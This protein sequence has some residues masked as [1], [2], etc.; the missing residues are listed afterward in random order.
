MNSVPPSRNT[1]PEAPRAG[2]YLLP[3]G[4][5]GIWPAVPPGRV[6]VRPAE[7]AGRERAVEN[8]S[9]VG[10]VGPVAGRVL[11]RSPAPRPFTGTATC[12][13]YAGHG[14]VGGLAGPADCPPAARG[15]AG[16]LRS[17]RSAPELWRTSW[18][19]P[20]TILI[21]GCAGR[22]TLWRRAGIPELAVA[23]PGR[24]ETG[25]AGATSDRTASSGQCAVKHE[26]SRSV[27]L[28]RP[29]PTLC[30]R[31]VRAF[32]EGPSTSGCSPGWSPGPAARSSR[33]VITDGR[34][35]RGARS[36][37]IRTGMRA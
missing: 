8:G 15:M 19:A 20:N 23:A 21:A 7:P 37:L 2:G 36:C 10:A 4:T 18:T 30:S 32:P 26:R 34:S 35:V 28:H 3:Y 24:R 27:Q 1:S 11:S 31:T 14:I 9:A 13:D 6:L 25:G 5:G 17:L 12:R 33:T 22:P 16:P 29:G